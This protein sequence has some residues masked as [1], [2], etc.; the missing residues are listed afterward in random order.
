MVVVG[1]LL[2]QIGPH[3]QERKGNHAQAVPITNGYQNPRQTHQEVVEIHTVS[4]KGLEPLET[5]KG[6][7]ELG[8]NKGSP[9]PSGQDGSKTLQADQDSEE[10]SE[11]NQGT[12]VHAREEQSGNHDR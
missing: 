11:N 9:H 10:Y 6:K 3:P 8:F 1:R 2:H 7:G 12:V 5:D 4:G